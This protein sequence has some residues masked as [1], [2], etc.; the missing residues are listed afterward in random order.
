MDTN[1]TPKDPRVH[2]RKMEGNSPR[3]LVEASLVSV[4]MPNA[5]CLLSAD[6]NA[7][8][9]GEPLT[10]L[11]TAVHRDVFDALPFSETNEDGIACKDID[12]GNGLTVQVT[13]DP[14]AG[15]TDDE[16]KDLIAVMEEHEEPICD[17]DLAIVDRLMEIPT[18]DPIRL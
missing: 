12:F 18:P 1:P 2:I 9:N 15:L 10:K 3:Y 6:W 13:V 11:Y 16:A 5:S 17:H 14:F 8:N 7:A 4:I